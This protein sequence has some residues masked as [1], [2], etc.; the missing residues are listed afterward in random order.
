MDMQQHAVEDG[1][2]GR[3]LMV[4]TPPLLENSRYAL[5]INIIAIHFV[6][7]CPGRAGGRHSIAWTISVDGRHSNANG[8]M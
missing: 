8:H 4:H 5:V 7:A 1:V 6:Y 2:N 3:P